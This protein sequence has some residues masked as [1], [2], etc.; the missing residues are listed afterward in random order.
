MPIDYD[1]FGGLG[2][3]WFRTEPLLE[4][5]GFVASDVLTDFNLA[6][7]VD[8][9]TF[10]LRLD[11]TGLYDADVAED[12]GRTSDL[13]I[14]RLSV[15]LED[16]VHDVEVTVGRQRRSNGGVLGR[17]DG[18]HAR[19]ELGWGISLSGVA[20]LPITSTSDSTPDTDLVVAAGAVEFE[21]IGLE[22]LRGEL[23]A[24]TRQTASMTDRAAVG[25]D[26]R[27][28]ASDW[29]AFAYFDYA[30]LFE[31]LNTAILSG[32][33]NWTD[34]TQ[35]RAQV[36]R[37]ATPV[38]QLRTALQ[39]Q[40]TPTL[41]DLHDVLS[42][43]EIRDLA[44]DRTQFI[45]SGSTGVTHRLDETFQLS[46]DLNVSWSSST[47]STINLLPA[48]DGNRIAG[49]DA[50]GPNV[51]ISS[52]LLVDDFPIEDGVGSLAVRYFEGDTSRA[53]IVSGFGRVPLP[54]GLRV[55]PRANWEWRDSRVQAA[56]ST[57]RNSL[58]L[59]WTDS[60]GRF[61]LT[62]DAEGGFEWVEAISGGQ[63]DRST[64]YFAELGIRC[65]F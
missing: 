16:E 61:D 41:E 33:W 48:G 55:S 26:L 62:V 47:K 52:Q 20:G 10:D 15:T 64:S 32:S 57:L 3:R 60:F 13:R 14:S 54:Y 5:A 34:E 24:V 63:Q 51:S 21:E 31:A 42:E 18:V 46:G 39:G 29:Y 38:F 37:R 65:R 28:S 8:A 45:W 22:G 4:D 59:I 19:G 9:P 49:I 30:F 11:F 23:F 7:R 44:K 35:F 40:S 1:V 25:G 36:E 17:F 27:F 2:L 6:G 58:E 53:F 43:D 56:R 50:V 12:S